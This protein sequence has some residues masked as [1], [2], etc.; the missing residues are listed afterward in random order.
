MPNIGGVEIL[1]ILV[2]LALIVVAVATGLVI[3]VVALTRRRR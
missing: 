2:V 1:I 3:G